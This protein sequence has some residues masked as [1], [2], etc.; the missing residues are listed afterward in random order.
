MGEMPTKD[1]VQAFLRERFF[2]K[3]LVVR[4]EPGM[5]EDCV[6][7]GDILEA[8]LERFPGLTIEDVRRMG[9]DVYVDLVVS[10]GDAA[11]MGGTV[12]AKWL[13]DHDDGWVH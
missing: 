12:A 5:S 11:Q 1:E 9:N 6:T 8:I 4:R 3:R 10:S 7:V 13:R 2:R